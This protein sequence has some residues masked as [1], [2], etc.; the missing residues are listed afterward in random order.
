MRNTLLA[1]VTQSDGF[2]IMATG[3]AK[4]ATLKEKHHAIARAINGREGQHSGDVG[5]GNLGTYSQCRSAS[6]AAI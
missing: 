3:A 5:T 4:V 1:G 6:V 2:R